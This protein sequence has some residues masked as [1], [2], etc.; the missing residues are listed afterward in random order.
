MM[1]GSAKSAEKHAEGMTPHFH[2]SVPPMWHESL[3]PVDWMTL[4]MA[5]VYYGMGVPRGDGSPVILVPGFLG[6][7]A[8]LYELYLWLQRVGYRPYMSK[9]GI[10]AECPGTLTKKLIKTVERISAETG[11]RTRIVGHSLGGVIGRRAS[12]LRPDLVSQLVYLGSPLQS[13]HVHP[14]VSAAVVM[15][16][17]ALSL[18]SSRHD[19]CLTAKCPCGF[20][21]DVGKR[22]PSSVSHAAI[23]TR[24]D[25]V[26]DW[27]DAQETQTRAQLRGRRDAHWTRLQPEG[28]QGAGETARGTATNAVIAHQRRM[29][30]AEGRA[31]ARPY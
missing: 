27:H 6:T 5:P 18:V 28:L 11:Q 17:T 3:W 9:I 12:L 26:V 23:Y 19:N 2:Q 7:D 10:N 14:A 15:L 25:G 22:L 16:H 24:S 31:I 29:T 13:V 4:R 8:Y 1:M 20:V 30:V 21:N